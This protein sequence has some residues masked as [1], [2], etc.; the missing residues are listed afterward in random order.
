MATSSLPGLVFRRGIVGR[1]KGW[2]LRVES[3]DLG[4]IDLDE[5]W[6]TVRIKC[7]DTNSVFAYK[8]LMFQQKRRIYILCL[9]IFLILYPYN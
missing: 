7:I 2:E 4:W 5:Q 1:D 8:S 6:K 9:T 3:W